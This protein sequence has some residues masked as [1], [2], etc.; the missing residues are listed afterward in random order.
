MERDMLMKLMQMVGD[1]NDR[2]EKLEK[3]NQDLKL[4]IVAMHSA[5]SESQRR[6]AMEQIIV[7]Q[8]KELQAQ[9][10]Q[11]KWL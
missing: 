11:A 8:E 5:Y 10:E 2:M 1:L 9:Q 6:A 3:E 7:N 4:H